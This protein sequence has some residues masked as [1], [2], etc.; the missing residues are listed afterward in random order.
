MTLAGGGLVTVGGTGVYVASAAEADGSPVGGGA[1]AVGLAVGDTN[2]DGD[3][4][5]DSAI[6]GDEAIWDGDV[7]TG[8]S[9]GGCVDAPVAIRVDSCVEVGL[10][11][12]RQAAIRVP[13]AAKP[14][15]TK[16]RLEIRSNMVA[17][18]SP[19]SSSFH[20]GIIYPPISPPHRSAGHLES[21]SLTPAIGSQQAP[22]ASL[23]LAPGHAHQSQTQPCDG[24]TPQDRRRCQCKWP[25]PHAAG[26]VPSYR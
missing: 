11:E 8:M 14:R 9:V 17:P 10:D 6:A 16:R 4:D 18:P 23:S 19:P 3:G 12:E 7:G 5:G 20:L 2:G 21:G 22:T 24:P 15:L 25:A 1:V 26:P 13:I